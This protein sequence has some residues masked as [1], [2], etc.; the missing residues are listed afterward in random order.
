MEE[1]K[2]IAVNLTVK[3]DKVVYDVS[4]QQYGLYIF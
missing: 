2:F 3:I 1:K 4:I